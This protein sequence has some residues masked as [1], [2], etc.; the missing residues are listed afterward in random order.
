MQNEQMLIR[1]KAK[2]IKHLKLMLFQVLSMEI[3]A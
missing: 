1:N 3:V 2:T